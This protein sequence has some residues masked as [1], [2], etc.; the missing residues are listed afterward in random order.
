M[1]PSDIGLPPADQMQ[2]T[3]D[4]RV[5]STRTEPGQSNR[6]HQ[7]QQANIEG[8]KP[9]FPRL[10]GKAADGGHREI[11]PSVQLRTQIGGGIFLLADERLK[12]SSRL[13]FVCDQGRIFPSGFLQL[14]ADERWIRVHQDLLAFVHDDYAVWTLAVGRHNILQAASRNVRQRQSVLV[15]TSDRQLLDQADAVAARRGIGVLLAVKPGGR[16]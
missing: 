11:Y 4:R 1:T 6:Q 10:P 3:L 15:Q 13:R 7:H 9:D 16:G 5:H 12:L 8:I 2:K 14:P